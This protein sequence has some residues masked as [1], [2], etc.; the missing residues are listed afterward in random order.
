VPVLSASGVRYSGFHQGAGENAVVDLLALDLPETSV[1]LI[2]EIETSLHPRAQR[3]LIRDFATMARHHHLQV[4]LTTHSP[5][6]LEEL[7]P[8]A[9]IYIARRQDGQREVLTGVSADYAMTYMDDIGH[10]ELELFVEDAESRILVEEILYR[11][12]KEFARRVAV[13][14]YGAA[15][16]GQALGQMSAQGRFARPTVVT[17]DGDQDAT[18][19]TH[20]LPGGDAPERVVFGGLREV[21]YQDLAA[22]TNRDHPTLVDAIV[23]ATALPNHHDWIQHAAEHV[24]MGG[25]DLWRAMCSVW[26]QHCLEQN[27]IQEL[28]D[29]IED[30]LG[31]A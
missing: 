1:V 20:A 25:G 14:T 2:D 30:C 21:N 22:R 19:G 10:P 28:L 7:P 8:E 31:G 11:H 4:I 17:L 27:Q 26:V 5:Y 15:N 23:G 9:R 24:V 6:V 13:V 29:D 18:Q 3:R 16:V 12:A